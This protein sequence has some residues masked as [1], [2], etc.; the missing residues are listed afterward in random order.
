MTRIGNGLH[1]RPLA[2]AVALV[3]LVLAGASAALAKGPKGKHGWGYGHG[4]HHKKGQVVKVVDMSPAGSLRVHNPTDFRFGVVLD[5]QNVGKVAPG[6]TL[7]LANVAAG[8]HQVQA[9]VIGMPNGPNQVMSAYVQPHSV[10]AV[11]LASPVASLK[12]RNMQPVAVSLHIDGHHRTTL[13]PGASARLDGLAA[14]THRVELVGPGGLI[15]GRQMRLEP[16]GRHKWAP[17][18]ALGAVTVRN[19]AQRPV[20]VSLANGATAHLA[21]GA[22]VTF[23][24]LAAGSH[25]LSV[26]GKHGQSVAATLAVRP[27]RTTSW[28]FL[29]PHPKKGPKGYGSSE[30]AWVY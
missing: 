1:L 7:V 19:G 11:S 28:T 6:G 4:H 25:S 22:A 30:V 3:A 10:A 5:G 20:T 2:V 27:N 15:A 18:A 21:P 24:G 23:D 8:N 26:T 12:V 17:P 9:R 13:A 29:P 14:G 16:G